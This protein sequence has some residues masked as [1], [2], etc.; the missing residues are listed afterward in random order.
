ME[1]VIF[2]NSGKILF[3]QFKNNVLNNSVTIAGYPENGKRKDKEGGR[4]DGNQYVFFYMDYFLRNE[5]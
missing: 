4:E 2:Q 5:I 1:E 3:V